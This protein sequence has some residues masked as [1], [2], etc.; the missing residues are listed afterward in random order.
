MWAD[1]QQKREDEALAGPTAER[2]L[3]IASPSRRMNRSS[4]S[5]GWSLRRLGNI[6][7]D[8]VQRGFRLAARIR[9]TSPIVVVAADGAVFF[10]LTLAA[11]TI[12]GVGQSVQPGHRDFAVAAFADPVLTAAHPFQRVFDACQLA[13]FHLGQLRTDLV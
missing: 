10:G 2:R 11:N 4:G 6:Q 13:A 3:A 1:P 5:A 9:D 7:F 8:V 12:G